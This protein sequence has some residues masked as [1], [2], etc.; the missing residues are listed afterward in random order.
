MEEKPVFW[1]D[2]NFNV[3]TKTGPLLA[4]TVGQNL[5]KQTLLKTNLSLKPWKQVNEQMTPTKRHNAT[6]ITHHL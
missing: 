1:G 5:L 6:V 4:P 2:K 3:S